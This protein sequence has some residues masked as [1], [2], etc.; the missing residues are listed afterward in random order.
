MHAWQAKPNARVLKPKVQK[1]LF[2]KPKRVVRRWENHWNDV[3][4]LQMLVLPRMAMMDG[5]L[6]K[7][8]PMKLPKVAPLTVGTSRLSAF[9]TQC[10]LMATSASL[11]A[12]SV[13]GSVVLECGL[14]TEVAFRALTRL[15]GLIQPREVPLLG[16]HDGM[17]P[18][19][20]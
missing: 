8:I 7:S 14:S 13:F 19:F 3:H 4:F 10:R 20:H 11:G 9:K 6:I 18:R 12:P 5:K 15:H 2:E 16:P 17:H 1:P